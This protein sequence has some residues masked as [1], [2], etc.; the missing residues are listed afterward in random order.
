MKKISAILIALCCG[1]QL[2]AA[3]TPMLVS[4]A[5]VEAHK[6]DPG[7]VLLQV[8]QNRKDFL[9][10]HIAGARF[11]WWQYLA[12]STPDESTTLPPL[13]EAKNRLEE[14]GVSNASRVILYGSPGM[15]T[16]L[17]RM[18]VT[19]EYLGL[20]WNVSI[21][22]GG[23]D[24]WKAEKR[25]VSTEPIP[26]VARGSV[27][28]KVNHAVTVDVEWVKS[29]L[30]NSAVNIVDARA[31]QAYDGTP[32]STQK[33]GHI[34][35]AKNVAYANMV[36]SLNC[37]KQPDT[38]KKYF[39]DAGV[40]ANSKVVTYCWVGQQATTTYFAARLAGYNAVVFD[41]SLDIWSAMDDSYPV[42]QTPPAP[43]SK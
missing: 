24:A 5:W 13:D 37:F 38:L 33:S 23:M 11:L 27:A 10:G 43:K 40:N 32:G 21:M 9:N 7:V 26:T 2:F 3:Q 6:N 42:E 1:L 8:S 34:L 39:A 4:T 29:N 31:K 20:G 14:L 25:A 35:G 12:P 15:V 30:K 16:L 36:D 17:T 22:N 41:G 19:F 18:Y 28:F